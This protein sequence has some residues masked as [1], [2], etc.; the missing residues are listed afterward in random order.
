[1]NETDSAVGPICIAPARLLFVRLPNCAG[2]KLLLYGACQRQML[3]QD[4]DRLGCELL[5]PEILG[6]ARLVRELIDVVG[7][8]LDLRPYEGMLE[9]VASQRTNMPTAVIY[10]GIWT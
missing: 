9:I 3:L 5:Y 6:R 1:M 8:I 4:R 2:S 10:P 7:V